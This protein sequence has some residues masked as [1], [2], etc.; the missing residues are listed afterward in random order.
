M[1]HCGIRTIHATI[2][3]YLIVALYTIQFHVETFIIV[4]TSLLLTQALWSVGGSLKKPDHSLVNL[5]LV[6]WQNLTTIEL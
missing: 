1:L 5:V 3:V 4:F 6:L 2:S